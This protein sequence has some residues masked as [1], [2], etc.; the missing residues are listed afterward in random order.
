[1][2]KHA[3]PIGRL[4]QTEPVRAAMRHAIA[5]ARND[6]GRRAFTEWM[7]AAGDAAHE[8]SEAVA[9]SELT[10]GLAELYLLG[11]LGDAAFNHSQVRS[12][13]VHRPDQTVV[14]RDLGLE[15][16]LAP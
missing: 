13:P 2:A 4:P 5:H 3:A 14:Q 15:S 10:L 12:C 9:E 6:V 11:V 16:E 7:E 8:S 1:M